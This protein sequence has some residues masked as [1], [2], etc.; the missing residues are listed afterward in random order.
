MWRGVDAEPEI[1]KE[2]GSSDRAASG[3]W[4]LSFSSAPSGCPLRPPAVTRRFFSYENAERFVRPL[5]QF[6]YPPLWQAALPGVGR[7]GTRRMP[8]EHDRNRRRHTIRGSASN[9][10]FRSHIFWRQFSPLDN[11]SP[12]SHKET[13]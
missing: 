6:S 8:F 5:L 11:C 9:Q 3:D 10:V 12:F 2:T 4:C 7:R 13:M 1:E